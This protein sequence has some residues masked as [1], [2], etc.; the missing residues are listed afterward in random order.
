VLGERRCNVLKINKVE[1]I[2]R[3]FRIKGKVKRGVRSL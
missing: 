2:E 1:V 3:K